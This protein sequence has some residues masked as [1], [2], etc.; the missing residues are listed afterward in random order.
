MSYFPPYISQRL[1]HGAAFF[2]TGVWRLRQFQNTFVKKYGKYVGLSEETLEK[3]KATF[4]EHDTKILICS[5]V[6]MG[7]GLALAILITA[8]MSRVSIKKYLALNFFGG[9]VWTACLLALGYFLGHA[10]L[11]IAEGL[12]I[13]FIIIAAL[14]FIISLY[15]FRKFMKKAL[16]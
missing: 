12:R 6:T 3:L 15:G 7:F 8:G 2:W 4:R 10:Y 13:S 16:K 11:L 9:V 14:I 5:K 1:M